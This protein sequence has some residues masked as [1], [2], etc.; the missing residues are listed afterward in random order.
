MREA[1]IVEVG[2]RFADEI[3]SSVIRVFRPA[4]HVGH[5]PHG[6]LLRARFACADHRRHGEGERPDFECEGVSL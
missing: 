2:T 1:Q 3:Y 6:A 4:K 5:G